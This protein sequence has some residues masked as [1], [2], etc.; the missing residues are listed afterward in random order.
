MD[1]LK[2]PLT[3]YLRKLILSLDHLHELVYLLLRNSRVC[4]RKLASWNRSVKHLLKIYRH[5][6]IS[7]NLIYL[8]TLNKTKISHYISNVGDVQ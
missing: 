5:M 4:L 3:I 2:K 6:S 8:T 1:V 7:Y